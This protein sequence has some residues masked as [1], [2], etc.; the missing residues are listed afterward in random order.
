MRIRH[1]ILA[2]IA[3]VLVFAASAQATTLVSYVASG[4]YATSQCENQIDCSPA[5]SYSG[6]SSCTKNCASG[7]PSAGSFVLS[8]TGS[9]LHP[10]SPC[11]SAKVQGSVEVTWT[12][13]TTTS[14][15]LTGHFAKSKDE[16]VLKVT[17]TGGTNPFF[18]PGPASKGF[19][20]H[21]P[22][23]CSPGSFAGSLRFRR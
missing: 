17:V 2:V 10:P 23:P 12:D 19:L 18:V 4:S 3:L 16:Y 6:S 8:L 22:S 21:P 11:I 9:A 7:A 1:T 15:S 20:N 14:A 5:Y 13:H